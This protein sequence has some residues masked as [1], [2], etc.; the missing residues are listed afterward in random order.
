MIELFVKIRAKYNK[1]NSVKREGLLHN[2]LITGVNLN[3]RQFLVAGHR[4]DRVMKNLVVIATQSNIGNVILATNG[5]CGNQ[6]EREKSEK[7]R[8]EM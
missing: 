5:F 6:H 7:E 3:D 2:K 8:E 1:E 4:M